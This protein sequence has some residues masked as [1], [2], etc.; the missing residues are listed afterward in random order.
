MKD[1][2]LDGGS[3]AVAETILASRSAHSQLDDFNGCHDHSF[4][5]AIRR[6]QGRLSKQTLSR[7]TQLSKAADA[8]RHITPAGL[9]DLLSTLGKE[10]T[11]AH[12]CMDASDRSADLDFR[13]YNGLNTKISTLS[14]KIDQLV[15]GTTSEL[16]SRMHAIEEKLDQ[17]VRGLRLG[18]FSL[19]QHSA[20]P[21]S[22][23]STPGLDVLDVAALN[24]DR[25]RPPFGD[26]NSIFAESLLVDRAAARHLVGSVVQRSLG[27]CHTRRCKRAEARWADWSRRVSVAEDGNAYLKFGLQVLLDQM[28]DRINGDTAKRLLELRS[29]RAGSLAT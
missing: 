29:R 20:A 27:R 13:A 24:S 10:M 25:Y 6:A 12:A 1:G 19:H 7:L 17:L 28:E 2:G 5:A 14:D 15:A 3:S 26:D 11:S 23:A 18:P 16:T 4:A 22:S 9:K 21:S 8:L